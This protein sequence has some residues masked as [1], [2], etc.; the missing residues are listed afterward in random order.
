MEALMNDEELVKS[1]LAHDDDVA[2]PS[3]H[4]R[5]IREGLGAFLSAAGPVAV[6]DPPVPR[7]VTR[8]ALR[9][10]VTTTLV[11]ALAAGGGFVAGRATAPQAPP[12]AAPSSAPVTVT[13]PLPSATPLP[14]SSDV[15]S[16]PPSTTAPPAHRPSAPAASDAFDREQ[17]LLER[18]RSALVR[19]DAD[20]AEKTLDEHARLF[21]RSHLAEERD[22]LRLQ[23]LHERGDDTELRERAKSFILKYPESMFRSRVEKLA[24]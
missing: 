19:H 1:L 21:P 11:A 22:Y 12:I 18:A 5:R 10:W 23:V 4:E 15:S 20:T 17:S 16:A 9:K 14:P 24:E 8:L 13:L 6:S 7:T 2:L 3:D